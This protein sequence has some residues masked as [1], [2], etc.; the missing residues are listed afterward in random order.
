M[1][2]AGGSVPAVG[3]PAPAEVRRRVLTAVNVAPIGE[4]TSDD[5]ELRWASPGTRHS[6]A[7][8]LR[9]NRLQG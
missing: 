4:E 6:W 2:E 3:C 7:P 8:G 5:R 9:E 1:N